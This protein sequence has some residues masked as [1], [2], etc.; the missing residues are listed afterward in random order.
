MEAYITLTIRDLK[1]LYVLGCSMLASGGVVVWRRMARGGG[2]KQR[3]DAA[4][5][6]RVKWLQ[7]RVMFGVAEQAREALDKALW[8]WGLMIE[9]E[10]RPIERGMLEKIQAGA[11]ND[12]ETELIDAVCAKIERL[13]WGEWEEREA[14]KELVKGTMELGIDM[15]KKGQIS[16]ICFILEPMRR[17]MSRSDMH[18]LLEDYG[19]LVVQAGGRDHRYTIW[20]G[21]LVV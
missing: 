13:H 7:E 19:L 20:G 10:I 5:M 9:K 16:G 4:L 17:N 1:V 15:A 18:R 2:R 11:L 8:V 3:E 21:V 14:R 6:E 12:R